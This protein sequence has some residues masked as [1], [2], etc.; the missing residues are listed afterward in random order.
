MYS[1]ERTNQNRTLT[2]EPIFI[3][4]ALENEGN[5]RRKRHFGMAINM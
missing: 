1:F 2:G 5:I 4:R 3:P